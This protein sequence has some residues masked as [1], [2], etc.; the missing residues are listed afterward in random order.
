MMINRILKGCF[1][2]SAFFCL[3]AFQAYSFDQSGVNMNADKVDFDYEK[4][5]T[6]FT[7]HVVIEQKDSS[8]RADKAVVYNKER[9]A[10]ASG[11]VMILNGNKLYFCDQITYD[12]NNN[13]GIMENVV[14]V[15]NAWIMTGSKVVQSSKDHIEIQNARITICTEEK[16]HYYMT[17]KNVTVESAKWIIARDVVFWFGPVPVFYFPYYKRSLDDDG[18]FGLRIGHDSKL[19]TEVMTHYDFFKS[20]SVKATAK[21][22]WYS[23]R[24]FGAGVETKNISEKGQGE[25]FA[26]FVNDRKFEP[27]R[28]L[29]QPGQKSRYAVSVN[30]TYRLPN[31]WGSIVEANKYSDADFYYDFFPNIFDQGI[32]LQNAAKVYDV[33]DW[34]SQGVSVNFKLNDFDNVLLR[35]PQYDFNIYEMQIGDSDFYYSSDNQVAYLKQDYFT[36]SPEYEAS[37]GYTNQAVSYS[38]K[39][40]GW[41]TFNPKIAVEGMLYS[42]TLSDE[43]IE[44]NGKRDYADGTFRYDEIFSLSLSTNLFKRFDTEYLHFG[45]DKFRHV[46]TPSID[47]TYS[48]SPSKKNN[49]IIQF[50][51]VDNRR[52]TNVIT[53]GLISMWQAKGDDNMIYNLVV[54]KYSISYNLDADTKPWGDLNLDSQLRLRKD[55]M[56]DILWSYNVEDS[57]TDSFRTDVSWEMSDIF[58][59]SM[60][61]WYRHNQDTLISPELS[62]KLGEEL[63]LRGY[64]YYNEGQSQVERKDISVVK[65]LHCMDLAFTYSVRENRDE[66]IFYFM[67]T[68]KSLSSKGLSFGWDALSSVY[69]AV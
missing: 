2:F 3:M 62:L 65:G 46:L 51:E 26:Y 19:G 20:N 43:V 40:F 17:A 23:S 7:G 32:Q 30:E 14:T 49:E 50:D 53:P 44:P 11:N 16:P 1:R 66:R 57:W 45:F 31:Q 48:P 39:Y 33:Q 59:V 15:K 9:K 25:A 58:G 52:R 4:N 8:L 29:D 34:Y 21:L 6:N 67:L 68:P 55:V 10:E 18:V 60:A 28:S 61:Y 36:D 63:F 41:L 35:F 27:T 5:I 56:A 37:R 47:Y 22:D 38:R 64:V 24:G 69:H 42:K 54:N 13:K 12:F